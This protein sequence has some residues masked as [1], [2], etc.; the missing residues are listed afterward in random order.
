M[1]EGSNHW[2]ELIADDIEFNGPVQQTKGKDDFIK[3]NQDFLQFVIG[4]NIHRHTASD[5]TVATEVTI[6]IKSPEE[7]KLS[8][9]LAEF[10][11]IVDGK[12]QSVKIY[13]D[14][15]EFIKKFM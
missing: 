14:P 1:H 13:Y 9:D 3:L 15:R 5:D 8:L 10:Y 2:Q 4:M 11:D 7:N 12:I 6:K